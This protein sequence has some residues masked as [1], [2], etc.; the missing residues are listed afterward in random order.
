MRFILC[1]WLGEISSCS[2]LTVLPGP[3]WVLLNKFCKEYISSLY[4]LGELT[5]L[6]GSARI[7]LENVKWRLY[8]CLAILTETSTE[9]L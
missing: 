2:F 1:T 7:Y 3:A 5:N 8:L 6:L 9:T 4:V